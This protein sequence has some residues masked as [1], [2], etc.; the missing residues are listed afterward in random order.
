MD[1]LCTILCENDMG[2]TLPIRIRLSNFV[3]Y[4]TVSFNTFARICTFARLCTRLRETENRHQ[5]HIILLLLDCSKKQ[6]QNTL[7][8]HGSKSR[9][10][11]AHP[12]QLLLRKKDIMIIFVLITRREFLYIEWNASISIS[13]RKQTIN[14]NKIL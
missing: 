13:K 8:T 9:H 6:D 10:Y 11:I 12:L 7:F 4:V 14:K 1:V 5:T 3:Y 2:P